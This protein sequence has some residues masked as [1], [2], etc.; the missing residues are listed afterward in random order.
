M[1]KI[2]LEDKKNTLL[3]EQSDNYIS[4][5][6]EAD[7]CHLM[8]RLQKKLNIGKIG[9]FEDHWFTFIWKGEL[10]GLYFSVSGLIYIVKDL[11]IDRPFSE[12]NVIEI[13]NQK[14]IGRLYHLNK[15]VTKLIEI[16]NNLNIGK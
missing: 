14:A 11:R 15:D 4:L 10:I 7:A 13:I 3:K 9:R 2:N 1:T 5:L 16:L 8:D 12:N 6:V